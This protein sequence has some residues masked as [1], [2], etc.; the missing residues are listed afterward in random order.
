MPSSR[1]ASLSLVGP[2]SPAVCSF[3]FWSIAS[4]WSCASLFH[5]PVGSRRRYSSHFA[6]AS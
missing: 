1:K 3:T 2:K 6:L 4:M 5:G